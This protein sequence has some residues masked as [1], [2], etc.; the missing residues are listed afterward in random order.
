MAFSKT[1]SVV[2][3]ISEA[4][5]KVADLV[6][7]I[8]AAKAA[9][10]QAE[11]A[12]TTAVLAGKDVDEAVDAAGKAAAK[13]RAFERAKTQA[14]ETVVALRKAK[15]AAD[16]AARREQAVAKLREVRDEA[17]DLRRTLVPLINR[18]RELVAFHDNTSRADFGRGVLYPLFSQLNATLLTPDI[19]REDADGIAAIIERNN[20]GVG[21]A[22]DLATRVVD[23]K[24]Q[25]IDRV[26]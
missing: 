16:N 2:D 10:E 18:V 5:Q 26:E 17:I 7:Q 12:A 1:K 23:L 20:D 22:D 25:P 24:P 8:T 3:P 21:L 4:E 9:F 6:Q 11:A 14:D 13:L 15:L 19:I